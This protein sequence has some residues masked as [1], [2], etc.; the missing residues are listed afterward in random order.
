MWRAY[1]HGAARPTQNCELFKASSLGW[2][3]GGHKST[4]R[5]SPFPSARTI[6]RLKMVLIQRHSYLHTNTCLSC[7]RPQT[8]AHIGDVRSTFLCSVVGGKDA[9]SPPGS[10]TCSQSPQKDQ[11]TCWE[12]VLSDRNWTGAALTSASN[13]APVSVM[14]TCRLFVENRV[15]I[16]RWFS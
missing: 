9:S 7:L 10:E 3:G 1:G 8:P 6:H 14:L 15:Q 2:W 11:E 4:F 5:N 12:A 16:F 13:P